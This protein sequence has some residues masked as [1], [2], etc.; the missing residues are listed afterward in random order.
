MSPHDGIN[1]NPPLQAAHSTTLR[2]VACS[3]FRCGFKSTGM[4]LVLLTHL[5]PSNTHALT[6]SPP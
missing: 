3:A 1:L 4:A 5:A 6:T 2:S